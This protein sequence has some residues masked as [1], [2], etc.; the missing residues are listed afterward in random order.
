MTANISKE[1]EFVRHG[2]EEAAGELISRLKPRSELR[3]TP[4]TAKIGQ[5]TEFRSLT[6]MGLER[7]F[8]LHGTLIKLIE[9]EQDKI[10]IAKK[11]GDSLGEP[12]YT[13]FSTNDITVVVEVGKDAISKFSA[14][15]RRF[16][17]KNFI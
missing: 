4:C 13:T 16:R 9:S 17:S 1:V 8:S 14:E 10:Q 3:I 11:R 12:E 7:Q 15:N 2:I 5:M 6:R